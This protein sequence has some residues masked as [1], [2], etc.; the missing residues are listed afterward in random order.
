VN[1]T[2]VHIVYNVMSLKLRTRNHPSL[3]GRFS[4]MPLIPVPTH[5]LQTVEMAIRH[6]RLTTSTESERVL[7]RWIYFHLRSKILFLAFL[8]WGGAIAPMPLMDP[9]LKGRFL[10]R[11]AMHPR[12]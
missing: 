6:T 10:P 7:F 2:L 11:D 5:V 9:P 12:Y 4:G 1:T 3:Q 8:G